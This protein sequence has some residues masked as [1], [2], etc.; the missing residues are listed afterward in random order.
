MERGQIPAILA[1]AVVVVLCA[2]SAHVSEARD[3]KQGFVV[4]GRVF[5][6]T[7]RAGFETPA[8][9]YIAGAKVS[10]ECR[11]KTSGAKTGSYNGVTDHTGTY[12]ILIAKEH[13]N[14][15]CESVL[16]SSADSGCA[17]LV[18]GRERARVFLTR[19]N[20][21]ATDFRFANALGFQKDTPVAGCAQLLKMYEENE[22]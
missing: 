8:T 6:D 20:G 9:T 21:I 7:C 15:I 4:Q 3:L 11:S 22:V 12:N 17:S 14:E 16:I 19:N 2:I 10:V 1:A 13:E 18:K 5:C